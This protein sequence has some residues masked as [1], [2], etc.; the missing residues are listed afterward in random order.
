MPSYHVAGALNTQQFAQA[1]RDIIVNLRL[2]RA[3]NTRRELVHVL[4]KGL[5]LSD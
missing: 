3:S 4:G 2:W 5:C 1:H